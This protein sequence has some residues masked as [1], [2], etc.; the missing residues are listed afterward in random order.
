MRERPILVLV[1]SPLVGVSAWQPVAGVLGA[2]GHV[3]IVPSM[4]E[5]FDGAGPYYSRLAATIANEIDQRG[6]DGRIVLVGHSG[7]GALL[8][9]V[10]GA[11]KATVVGTIF[12]DA[13][14][15]HPGRSWFDTVPVEM[16]EQLRGLAR[17]GLLPPWNEWFPP[18]TVEALLPD[19]AMRAHF[20]S[21]LPRLP[22]SY[23][24]EPAPDIPGPAPS[25]CGYL[26]LSEAYA[27]GADQ[28]EREGWRVTRRDTH[29]LALLTEPQELSA[30]LEKLINGCQRAT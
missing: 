24:E 2:R 13:V 22:L 25:Y 12:V 9:A 11:T 8:P 15:P 1:H 21:E 26:Q 4:A 3:T 10:A 16:H 5:V 28:A 29:H 20:C 7:A 18:G 19:A 14:L 23:F 27:A 30:A 17:D 6:S